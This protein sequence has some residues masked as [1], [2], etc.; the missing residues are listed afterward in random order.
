MLEKAGQPWMAIEI[1]RAS[2][3][4]LSKGFDMACADLAVTHRCVVYPGQES[5]ALRHGAE[6][7][8]LPELMQRLQQG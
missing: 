6:A 1:K 4:A 5:F 8:G 3:P 7:L 2:A